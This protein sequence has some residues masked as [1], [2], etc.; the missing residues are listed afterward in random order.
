MTALLPQAALTPERDDDH[1]TM[2]DCST[3]LKASQ[4][5][6][7]RYEFVLI[8][9][10][11]E[12]WAHLHGRTDCHSRGH[13]WVSGVSNIEQVV[14]K[15][16]DFLPDVPELC[17]FLRAGLNRMLLSLQLFGF[18]KGI[19]VESPPEPSLHFEVAG[20]LLREGAVGDVCHLQSLPQWRCL[21]QSSCMEIGIKDFRDYGSSKD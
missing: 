19:K 3:D 18:Y 4:R 7:W 17:N 20:H 12:S 9:S 10:E 16:K 5:D 21:C 2:L 1:S 14:E 6:L 15:W 8:V 11:V 13:A